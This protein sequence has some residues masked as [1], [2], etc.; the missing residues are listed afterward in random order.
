MNYQD[1]FNN[2]RPAWLEINL[3]NYGHNIKLIKEQLQKRTLL[4]AVVKADA[5]GHGAVEISKKALESG[6]DRLAVAILDEAEELRKSGLSEVPILILGWTPKEQYER[7]IKHNLIQTIYDYQDVLALNKAAEKLGK[8]AKIHIK[9]DTGMSRLGIKAKQGLKFVKKVNDLSSI[10]IEGI[11]T[12][13]SSADEA[14]KEFTFQQFNLFKGLISRLKKNDINIPV[15]HAANSAATID[16]PELQMDMVRVGIISY[17]LW[18]SK[19]V[20]RK[21]DLKAVMSL[22]SRL[23]YVKTVE[24]GTPISYGRTYVTEKKSKIGTIPL[25][26]AD[27]YS[28]LL[29][30]NFEII[31]K[32]KRAPIIGRI[33]MDQ[34]M[35]DLSDIK[36]VKKGDIVTLLGR[37]NGEV[38]TADE[39]AEK[40][41]TINYEVVSS[42]TKR[43]PRVYIE[44]K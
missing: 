30:S 32:G 26:Y 44:N 6:A 2:I 15:K 7:V 42:F 36:S 41:D 43:L 11:Y 9:I 4:T 39:M 22:K 16:M 27:G 19:E 35:V 33:C 21:I 1:K 34:F 24:K 38:I 12:H 14:D 8:K 25:G 10:I 31:V 37:D 29:S 5:Y 18:P 28:R 17:G 13:F 40:L 23:A 3:D 20:K